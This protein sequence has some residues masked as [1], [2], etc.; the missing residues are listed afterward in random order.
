MTPM[1]YHLAQINVARLR[2]PI[3]DP[4][5]RDFVDSV[6][7]VNA[8]AEAQPGFVWRPVGDS[9]N[10][11][12]IRVGDDPN[13][14]VHISVRTYLEA[15]AAFV[16]R[17]PAYREIMRRRREWFDRREVFMALW[18][19]PAR[20]RPT[21]T[22][23]MARLDR[24]ARLGPTAEALLCTRPFPAPDAPLVSPL[25]DQCAKSVVAVLRRR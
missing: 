2:A 1:S 10:A 21:V 3:A 16:Y 22:E 24:L 4:V 18:W 25:L 17:T 14:I 23:G 12:D 20:H 5:N 7:R 15:L 9:G 13:L 6:D 19:V 8:V 11:P